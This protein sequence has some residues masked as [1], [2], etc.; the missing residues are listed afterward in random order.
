M[1]KEEVKKNVNW[2]F[3]V[4]KELYCLKRDTFLAFVIDVFE[5]VPQLVLYT[6]KKN[7]STKEKLP[8]Q[9]QR[10]AP[11]LDRAE[12]TLMLSPRLKS[13]FIPTGTWI[14]SR[15]FYRS[16]RSDCQPGG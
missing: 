14:D 15:F 3:D 8:L 1:L 5:G 16:Q 12:F 10:G 11:H 6:V 13:E 4:N 9:H 7:G 2:D